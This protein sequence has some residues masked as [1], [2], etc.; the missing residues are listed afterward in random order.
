MA[1]FQ[2]IWLTDCA[3]GRFPTVADV[4]TLGRE[5]LNEFGRSVVPDRGYPCLP[6]RFQCQPLST[7]LEGV[8]QAVKRFFDN[9]LYYSRPTAEES[10]D[11][12]I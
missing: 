3:V 1:G 12:R 4:K 8:E 10:V 6:T 7:D 2:T 11:V 5:F 9:N